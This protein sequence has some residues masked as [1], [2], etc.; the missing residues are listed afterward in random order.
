MQDDTDEYLL[1]S[2]IQHYAFCKRQW[3]MIYIESV[4]EENERTVSGTILHERAHNSLITEKRG[5]LIITHDLPVLSHR[6]KIV[7]KCDVVEFLRNDIEGVNLFGRKGKWQPFPV[8]YK[9][10][11]PK[12]SDI[13]RLQLC[14]Q[15]MCLE[16]MLLCPSIKIAYLY[17]GET[18]RRETVQLISELR[19]QV[20]KLFAEMHKAYKQHNTFQAK[21]SR[22]CNSC[23]IKDICLPGLPVESGAVRTYLNEQLK[24][25]L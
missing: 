3:A 18:K 25:I 13:D 12:I 16:E 20:D 19:N 21:P 4:W 22:S 15:A 10:G 11:N 5:N 2:G 7:G 8:E 9:R 23:S 14:A 17:Y 6:L 24:D 1:L